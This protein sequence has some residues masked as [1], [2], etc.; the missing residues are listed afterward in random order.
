MKIL[1]ATDNHIGYAEKDPVRG[2]DSLNTFEEILKIACANSVDL[3]LLGGDLFHDN[4]P[5][6]QALH[7]TMTLLRNYCAF[8][9]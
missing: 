8:A 6:R 7:Q 9:Y 3:I 1:I 5:S 4:K 2:Q